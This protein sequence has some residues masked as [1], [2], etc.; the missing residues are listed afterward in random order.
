MFQIGFIILAG[1]TF[2]Y[3][4]AFVRSQTKF[5]FRIILLFYMPLSNP[6]LFCFNNFRDGEEKN[7]V[8]GSNCPHEL[9]FAENTTASTQLE[10]LEFSV[11]LLFSDWFSHAD[12][13]GLILI[14]VECALVE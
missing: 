3:Y 8:A 12:I 10:L 4:A 1:L 5:Y 13:Y 11:S 6:F 7:L 2:V 14:D 9:C